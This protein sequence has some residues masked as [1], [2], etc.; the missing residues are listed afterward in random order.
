MIIIIIITVFQATR[1]IAIM[2]GFAEAL[3]EL[4]NSR[5]CFFSSNRSE[6][7]FLR[8]H[9]LLGGRVSLI[10]LIQVYPSANI[11]QPICFVLISK[12]DYQAHVG[13]RSL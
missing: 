3:L 12:D 10:F 2:L 5:T 13:Q 8:L 6:C 1:T 4:K 11:L 9:A 7:S